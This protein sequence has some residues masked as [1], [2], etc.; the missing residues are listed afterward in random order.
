MQELSL[1]H[2]DYT[3]GLH[4]LIRYG[5]RRGHCG[6]GKCTPCHACRFEE[7]LIFR[8]QSVDMAGNQASDAD[9]DQPGDGLD[10]SWQQPGLESLFQD[11]LTH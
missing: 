5:Y 11:A 8:R 7:D 4:D 9:R 6:N 10:P 3:A 2:P 1:V